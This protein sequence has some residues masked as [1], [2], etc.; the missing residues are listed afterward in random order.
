MT[1]LEHKRKLRRKTTAEEFTCPELVSEMLDKLPFEVF[2]DSS[3]TFIDNSAGN[4]NFLV[5]ILRRKLALKHP[6]LQALS[7]I[8]AIELMPDN[9]E[10]MKSRLLQLLPELSEADLAEANRIINHNIVCADALKFDYENWCKPTEYK[11]KALLPKE[12]EKHV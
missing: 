3:K 10:E 1:E 4:G 8:Y 9:V 2:T 6:P 12:F 5:E 7:T 11:A